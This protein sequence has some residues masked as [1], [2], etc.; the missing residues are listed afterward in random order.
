[1]GGDMLT[2]VANGYANNNANANLTHV[3]YRVKYG[4]TG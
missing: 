3:I 1:M 4:D 2:G